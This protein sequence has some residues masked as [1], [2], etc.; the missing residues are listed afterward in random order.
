MLSFELF[1]DKFD[2][3]ARQSIRAAYDDARSRQDNQMKS[4]HLL[5]AI[6]RTSPS[7]FNAVMQSLNLDPQVVLQA[8]VIT[9]KPAIC[10][11]PSSKTGG[12]PAAGSS[13]GSAPPQKSSGR[14]L[15]GRFAAAQRQP[16]SHHPS[17]EVINK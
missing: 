6:A 17:K 15:K 3:S 5:I 2:E 14:R 8:I 11:P 16:P 4:E 1:T 10:F 13:G 7:F 9:S 12:M